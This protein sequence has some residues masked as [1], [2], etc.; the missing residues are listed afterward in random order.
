MIVSWEYQSY[1]KKRAFTVLSRSA[2]TDFNS[3]LQYQAVLTILHK[4]LLITLSDCTDC[5]KFL[6]M[7]SEQHIEEIVLIVQQLSISDK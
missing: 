1:L 5:I 7:Q 3:S 4:Q 6:F 2:S